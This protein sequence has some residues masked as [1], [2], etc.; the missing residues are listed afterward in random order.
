MVP[1]KWLEIPTIRLSDGPNGVRGTRFFDSI[2][3]R[4]LSNGTAIG[5]IFDVDLATRIVI[6][7]RPI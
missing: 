6:I 7:S 5:A 2:P 3:S 4:C 1:I